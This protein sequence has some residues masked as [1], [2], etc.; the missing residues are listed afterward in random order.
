MFPFVLFV[1]VSATLS[2]AYFNFLWQCS[3]S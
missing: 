2:L 3:F 1:V